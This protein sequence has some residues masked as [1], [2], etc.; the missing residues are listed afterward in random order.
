[1]TNLIHILD[2]EFDINYPNKKDTLT[3][4]KHNNDKTISRIN[5]IPITPMISVL[6][7]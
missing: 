6:I 2:S 5:N 4:V 1:M 7:F 3:N